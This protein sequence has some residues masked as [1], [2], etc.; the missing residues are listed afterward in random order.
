MRRATEDATGAAVRVTI[1]VE[2]FV[3]KLNLFAADDGGNSGTTEEGDTMGGPGGVLSVSRSEALCV[4]PGSLVS[5][6]SRCSHPPTTR[7]EEVEEAQQAEDSK[8]R[9]SDDT[10]D[11]RNRSSLSRRYDRVARDVCAAR[12]AAACGV[13]V[14]FEQTSWLPVG[15]SLCLYD[16]PSCTASSLSFSK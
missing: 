11:D 7:N 13:T 6:H 5:R 8:E 1:P 3:A 4:R 16:H 10:H 2:P 9:H 12:G 15:V 14:D